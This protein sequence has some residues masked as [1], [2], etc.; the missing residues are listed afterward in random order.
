MNCKTFCQFPS[1][2]APNHAVYSVMQC[3]QAGLQQILDDALLHDLQHVGFD[4]RRALLLHLLPLSGRLLRGRPCVRRLSRLFAAPGESLRTLALLRTLRIFAMLRALAL[5]GA[6]T[7]LRAFSLLTALR[8]FS[9]VRLLAAFRALAPLGPVAPLRL[10]P[11]LRFFA[12]LALRRGRRL[13]PLAVVD[14][15]LA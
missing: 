2:F 4:D 5:G 8:V 1:I 12:A 14:G 7:A 6:L 15:I 11:A 3:K 10:F 9:P 13:G